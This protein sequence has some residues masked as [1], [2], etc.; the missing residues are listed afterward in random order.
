MVLLID[1]NII[2][3]SIVLRTI[4]KCNGCPETNNS[5]AYRN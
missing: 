5:K 4:T 1:E 2:L 3:K